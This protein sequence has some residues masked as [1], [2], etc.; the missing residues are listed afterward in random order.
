MNRQE[1][2]FTLIELMIGLAIFAILLMLAG[3]QLAL[4]LGNSQIRN[5]ADAMLNGVQ[6]AQTA[7][8]KANSVTR[9]LVDTTTGT[10]GWQVLQTV[11]GV[12]GQLQTFSLQDG[13]PKVSV[14]TVPANARQIT[15]DG[16]G[17]IIPNVDASATLT[18]MK[19]DN[20]DFSSY[21]SRRKLNV[22]ITS[23][24]LNVG[25]K[26]CDPGVATTEPQGCPGGCT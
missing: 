9:L 20:P 8:I 11:E 2:G 14:T 10:G 15:F 18:C 13:A 5:G 3:P 25:T 6:Q 7:A 22:A 4:M 21:G 23:L 1:T 12:E 17:R 16:F 24:G 26:L 19:I